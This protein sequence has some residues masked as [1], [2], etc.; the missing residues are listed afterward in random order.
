MFVDA[1]QLPAEAIVETGVCIVGAGAAGITLACELARRHVDVCVVESGGFAPDASTQSLYEAENAGLSYFPLDANRQRSYGGSTNLWAGWCRPLDA[2]DL[3]PRAWVPHSGWPI[4]ASELRPYYQRA[5]TVCELPPCTYDPG[6]WEQ[7]SLP[8]PSE[9]VVGKLYRLSPPTRFG[10]TYR[11]LLARAQ[12]VQVLLHANAAHIETN[13]TATMVTRLCLR[14]Q[15]GSTFGVQARHYVLA[16][17]GIENARLLLLSDAV[18]PSG[19]GNQHGIVGRYFMEHIHFPAATLVLT[20]AAARMLAEVHAAQHPPPRLAL[21]ASLQ[22]RERL[23]NHSLMLAPVHWHDR[24]VQAVTRRLARRVHPLGNRLPRSFDPGV[25]PNAGAL[26]RLSAP[27]RA[28]RWHLH[29][30]LEQAPNPE[31]RVTLSR[32]HDALGLRRACLTWRTTPLDEHTA[33]RVPQLIVAEFI[34]SGR[35]RPEHVT[36][37]TPWPPAPLQGVRGHHMGTTRMSSDARHGVVDANCRVHGV[38]NLFIAGSSVFPTAGA[39]APTLTI[40]ALALRLADQLQ[41]RR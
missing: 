5:H 30:T 26:A 2:F 4:S 21:S 9:Q 39:G 24:I 36:A 10:R 1:R 18:Q 3:A 27:R 41:V 7:P 32:Q 15:S 12:N 33:G 23:L 25:T 14:C 40:V 29:C 13:E 22:A 31:S 11:E 28:R 6:D 19:L 37:I 34:A 35:G 16:T 20:N 8:L 17:G 38:V